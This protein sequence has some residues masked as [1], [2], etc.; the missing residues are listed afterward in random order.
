MKK[1][2]EQRFG[3]Q[4]TDF[5]CYDST[6]FNFFSEVIV[7]RCVQFFLFLSFLCVSFL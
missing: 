2:K 6:R 3:N 4:V 1:E 7:Y 5:Q